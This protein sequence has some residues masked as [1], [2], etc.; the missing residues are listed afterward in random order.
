MEIKIYNRLADLDAIAKEWDELSLQAPQQNPIMS[1]AWL[2]CFFSVYGHDLNWFV[3]TAFV[4]DKLVAVIPL[5]VRKKKT[6]LGEVEYLQLPQDSH[7]LSVDACI[8]FGHQSLLHSLH[9][10]AFRYYPRACYIEYVRIDAVS[11]NYNWLNNRKG[12]QIQTDLNA[13]G[14]SVA[15]P[16]SYEEY[17]TSLSKNHRSNL[18]RWSNKLKNFT[19]VEVVYSGEDSEELFQAVF[20]LEHSGWI[21]RAGSS[22][23]SDPQAIHYFHCLAKSLSSKGWLCYQ[24]LKVDNTYIAGNFSIQFNKRQLLWKLAYSDAHSKMSPGSLLLSDVIKR[25]IASNIK[26]DLMTNESWYE[27]WN[28]VRREFIDIRVYGLGV[29]STLL[30]ACNKLRSVLSDVKLMLNRVVRHS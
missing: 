15:S 13:Y 29:K 12:L 2:S 5:V 17:L 22:V 1:H 24:L 20:A 19:Q 9:K 16:P 28:M 27:N 18:N 6:F 23:L 14:Y 3:M 11:E 7:T 25:A 30:M 26:V 21:G 8:L 4:D 10:A